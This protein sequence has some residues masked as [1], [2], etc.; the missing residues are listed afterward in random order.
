MEL[1]TRDMVLVIQGLVILF[2]GALAYLFTPW[3]GRIVARW[4]AAKIARETNRG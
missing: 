2:S 4:R 3:V 1:I